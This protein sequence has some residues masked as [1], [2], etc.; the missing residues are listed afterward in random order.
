M[1]KERE[2]PV[3]MQVPDEGIDCRLNA[4]AADDSPAAGPFTQEP[5]TRSNENCSLWLDTYLPI[6]IGT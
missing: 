3:G 2:V 6:Y 1:S 5:N 4:P